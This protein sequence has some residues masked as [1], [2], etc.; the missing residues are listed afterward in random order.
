M[1]ARVEVFKQKIQ[2]VDI[3]S[4]QGIISTLFDR[5]IFRLSDRDMCDSVSNGSFNKRCHLKL[6]IFIIF[7]CQHTTVIRRTFDKEKRCKK[8]QEALGLSTVLRIYKIRKIKLTA[9][10]QKIC[11]RYY[12]FI[13]WSENIQSNKTSNWSFNKRCHLKFSIFFSC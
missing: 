10:G 9:Q 8:E 11:P 7:S 5:E 2:S 4:S 3:D 12:F 6:S 13:F 1:G